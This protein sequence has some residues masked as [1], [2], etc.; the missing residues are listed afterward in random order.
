VGRKEQSRLTASNWEGVKGVYE[1]HLSFTWLTLGAW[2]W[3]WIRE[4]EA[5]AQVVLSCAESQGVWKQ[6]WPSELSLKRR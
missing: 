2:M 3:E 6:A 4:A 1:L 5:A